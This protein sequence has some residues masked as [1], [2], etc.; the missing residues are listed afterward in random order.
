M[1]KIGILS[2][3]LAF[4]FSTTAIANNNDP[5]ESST[6]SL[7]VNTTASDLKWTGYKVTGKHYGSVGLKQGKLDMKDGQLTGG[8]FVIDMTSITVEDLSGGTKDKLE[9]HLKSS[10]FFGVENHPEAMLQ[11]TEVT[12][13]GVNRYKI[14]ADLTIK[15]IT[16]PIKFYAT[17]E[18]ENGITVATAEMT[19]DRSEYNV[20]YGSGSFFDNLGDKTIYDDFDL[21]VKIVAE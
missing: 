1:K 12:P 19:I 2:L 18:M 13:N 7:S 21:T 5:V 20:R 3:I 8:M 15:D 16:K 9:G 17:T 10:D 11:I 6:Q 4:A 14:E